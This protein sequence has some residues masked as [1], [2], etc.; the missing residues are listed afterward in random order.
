MGMRGQLRDDN[1]ERRR[2]YPP[3]AN[4][5]NEQ[6]HA[7]RKSYITSVHPT[8]SWDVFEAGDQ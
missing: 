5:N 3:A 1:D 8:S 7:Y 6:N 2:E 4:S